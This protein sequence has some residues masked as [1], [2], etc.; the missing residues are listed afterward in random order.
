MNLAVAHPVFR[1]HR[2][3]G[4]GDDHG[5]RHTD[6]DGDGQVGEDLALGISGEDDRQE[7][8]DGGG[9]RGQERA[10][11]LAGTLVGGRVGILAHLATA[12]DVFQHDDRRIHHHAR[13]EGEPGQ[14]DHV[15]RAAQEEE[16]DQGGEQRD[17][18]GERDDQ[19]RPGPA[20]E[21]PETEDRQDH[22][23]HQIGAQ[24]VDGPHDEDRGVE[25]GRH[26]QLPVG[27]EGLVDHRDF[28]LH[29][30]QGREDIGALLAAHLDAHGGI[31]VLVGEIVAL[32]IGDLHR[33]DVGETHRC[34]IAPD[35]DQI[36]HL[37]RLELTL[38]THLV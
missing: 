35:D 19:R 27:Q 4:D 28:G 32:A 22:A 3:D 14:R 12:D 6:G 20:Q 5:D 26:H 10:P 29:G 18:D 25:R 34:A 8:G 2:Q 11:D 15:E 33:G 30:I 31:A 16:H 38:E 21:E 17:R 9:G 37:G 7:D 13:R 1:H 24:K 36:A 23:E